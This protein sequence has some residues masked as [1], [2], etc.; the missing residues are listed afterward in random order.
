MTP[1]KIMVDCDGDYSLDIYQDLW[2]RQ[3]AACLN[4][5]TRKAIFINIRIIDRVFLVILHKDH[6][7]GHKYDQIA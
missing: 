5:D 2:E 6:I 1:R 3:P 4:A 7:K